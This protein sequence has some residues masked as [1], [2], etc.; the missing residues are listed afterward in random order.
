MATLIDSSVIIEA[1]RG[2]LDLAAVAA[3][4]RDPLLAIS[5]ITASELLVGLH[6]LRDGGKKARAEAFVEAVLADLPI[7]PFDLLCARAHTAVGAELRRKGAMV[8][9]HDLLI[10]ATAIA[11]GFS[12][13]TCDERSFPRIP[14]LEVEL[15]ATS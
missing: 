12:V 4:A 3:R 8:G 11:R 5:A 9:E 1:Q 13:A 7:V 10:A 14:G 2:R 15:F 6:L